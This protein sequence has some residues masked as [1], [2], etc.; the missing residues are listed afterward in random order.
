[1]KLVKTAILAL[2]LFAHTVQAQTAGM[3]MPMPMPVPISAPVEADALALYGDANLGNATTEIWT[4]M[5]DITMVRNVTLP[6]LTPFLPK[7]GKATGAA[8]IIAP[9]GAFMG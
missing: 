8:V 3:P 5:G 7:P 9:G 1:M 4:N 6:T 2:A